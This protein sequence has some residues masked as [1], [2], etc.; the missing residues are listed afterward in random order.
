MKPTEISI[1]RVVPTIVAA[2]P[3][4][5]SAAV[6]NAETIGLI[7]TEKI[8]AATNAPTRLLEIFW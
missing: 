5:F 8:N 3:D 2:A 6:V 7:R 4:R 1:V